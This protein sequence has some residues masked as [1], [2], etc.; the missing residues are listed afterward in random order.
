MADPARPRSPLAMVLLALVWEGPMHPYRMQQLIE[1]RGKDK[2]ANVARRNSVYQTIESL[3]RSGLIAVR[4]TARD[5]GRPERTVYAITEEG[6]RTLRLWLSTMISTPAREFPDFPAALSM[7]ALF[8]PDLVGDLLEERVRH[9]TE[10]LGELSDPGIE[11]PR[12]FT[13]E[14]EYQR[15]MTEAEL[16]WVRGVIA[17]LRSGSLAWDPEWVLSVAEAMGHVTGSGPE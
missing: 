13:I 1:Q 7:V 2:I 12:L 10:R 4:E 3:R 11:M 5:E 8:T 9:L 17:D 6:D 15:V 16:G 14:D